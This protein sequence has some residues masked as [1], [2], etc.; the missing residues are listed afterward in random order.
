MRLYAAI[1]RSRPLLLAV[2]AMLPLG[3]GTVPDAPQN[4]AWE[5]FLARARSPILKNDKDPDPDLLGWE[6]V[7]QERAQ[8]EQQRLAKQPKV[9]AAFVDLGIRD[10]LFEISTQS[11]IPVVVDQGV[12]GNVT[13]DLKDIPFESALRLVVFAGGYAY[14]TDGFA[15]YVGTLDPNSPSYS[16]LTTSRVIPTYLP[17]KQVAAS[18][19][20]AYQN[21][22]TFAEGTNKLVLTGPS[23]ILD[24]LEADVRAIDRPP[25]QVMI[26]VLVVET[27]FG[28]NTDLGLEYGKLESTFSHQITP[29]NQTVPKLNQ[30]DL[31]SQLALT[32]NMLEVKNLATVRSHPKIV[33]SSGTTAEIRSQ[34]ENYV[35]IT[36]PGVTF[37]QTNLE[38][39]KS[40]TIL[41]VTPTV[42][43]ND[44]IELILEPEVSD[45]VGVTADAS[46]SLPVISRRTVKSTVRLKN[47]DV[48]TIG[49]LYA[50]HSRDSLRGLPIL[51][52]MPIV[53]LATAQQSKIGLTSEL[54]IFVS[55][56]VIR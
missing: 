24:R 21:F 15:Y 32:F 17:P 38:I 34:V 47:G 23:A 50:E 36:R 25:V 29:G 53:N 11:K 13:L 20:K 37:F 54:L 5:D 26:E 18:L 35:L 8:A 3:C 2:A 27:K 1:R 40:G 39:I 52:D 49:G 10:A 6:K 14:S 41:K 43:R 33:T 12:A 56:K 28:N 7:L 51:K 16:L 19:G 42:T 22:A 55:P 44:E 9:S 45:V 46:G 4:R 48:L 30:L 31:I